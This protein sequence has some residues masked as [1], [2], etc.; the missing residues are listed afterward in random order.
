[1][2][3]TADAGAE[4]AQ[5]RH[6][7]AKALTAGKPKLGLVD[8]AVVHGLAGTLS[9]TKGQQQTGCREE[10][11]QHQ[12]SDHGD[13]HANHSLHQIGA[14]GSDTGIEN[15]GG[16]LLGKLTAGGLQTAGNKA[17]GQG[18]I[19]DHFH[20]IIAAAVINLGIKEPDIEKLIVNHR[21]DQQKNTCQNGCG[22]QGCLQNRNRLFQGICYQ[23][24]D[25]QDRKN[26]KKSPNTIV[27]KSFHFLPP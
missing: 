11:G 7:K 19:G 13:T 22:D 15:L 9:E 14:D 6:S 12:G 26:I 20:I 16:T 25:Q 8:I 5:C 21:E 23:Q 4:E 24:A 1:M 18:M 17:Q 3:D 2:D 10:F 27:P